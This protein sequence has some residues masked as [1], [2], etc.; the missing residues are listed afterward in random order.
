MVYLFIKRVVKYLINLIFGDIVK[1]TLVLLI[2]LEFLK[3]SW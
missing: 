2:N 3:K 1:N